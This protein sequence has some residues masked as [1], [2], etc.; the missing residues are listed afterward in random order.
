MINLITTEEYPDPYTGQ[1]VRVQKR[2]LTWEK[3]VAGGILMGL[4]GTTSALLKE[5]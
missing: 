1:P 5:M 3:G 2:Y 4:I